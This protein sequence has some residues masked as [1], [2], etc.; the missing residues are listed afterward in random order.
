M[1]QIVAASLGRE[2]EGHPGA[3][4]RLD[5]IAAVGAARICEHG[6]RRTD[7]PLQVLMGS[8]DLVHGPIEWQPIQQGVGP[9]VRHQGHAFQRQA[10]QLVPSQHV[11]RGIRACATENGDQLLDHPHR[12]VMRA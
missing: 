5:G 9:R 6:G 4:G 3:T 2:R 7:L 10:P 12:L 1:P 8:D 11:A